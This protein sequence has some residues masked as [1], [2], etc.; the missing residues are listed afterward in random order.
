MDQSIDWNNYRAFLNCQKAE[1]LL[2]PGQ[3][4][5]LR[6]VRKDLRGKFEKTCAERRL[7][8]LEKHLDTKGIQTISKF[9]KLRA[10]DGFQ[11]VKR[12]NYSRII[13]L[14]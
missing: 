1:N 13:N 2:K 5:G 14:I 4:W 3:L 10:P 6:H 8:Q 11:V 7:T 9:M 12:I